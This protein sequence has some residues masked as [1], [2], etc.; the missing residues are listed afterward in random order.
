MRRRDFLLAVPPLVV[1][2][3]GLPGCNQ[4]S[5][6]RI[7]THAWPGY[8]SLPLAR[9]FGWLPKATQL[10]DGKGATDSL[11]ALAA[12]Q[13][14]GA[15]LTLDELLLARDRGISLSAVLVLDES[16]GADVVLARPQIKRLEDLRHKRIGV[17]PGAVGSLVLIKLLDAAGFGPQE[18]TVVDLRPEK[19]IAAWREG[20]VDALISYA[21]TA[22]VIQ[23]DGGRLLFDS[24]NFP[25]T[26]FD[27]LAI[28]Q[29]RLKVLG[30][31][32]EATIAAHFRAL[33]HLRINREDALR[34]IAAWRGLSY[35]EMVMS[36]AG[37]HLPEPPANRR[38]LAP[39]GDILHA[40]RNLLAIMRNNQLLKTGSDLENLIDS[41]FLPRTYL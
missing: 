9:H 26:I 16:V 11:A 28:R 12:D 23:R 25:G 17:E 18:V 35:E 4:D 15:C 13:I 40:A 14:D 31:L 5:S 32:I 37:L 20:T 1:A 2:S 7:G 8:E 30:P 24:R 34:R 6:L 33:E 21:P 10:V 39:S 22:T 19:Q 36:Y 29:D 3:I 41:R 38:M 27:V